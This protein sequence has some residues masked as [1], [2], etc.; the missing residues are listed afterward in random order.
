MDM[1]SMM[2]MMNIS[3][4]S[5]A[6]P[7]FLISIGQLMI[8]WSILILTVR[9]EDVLD[10]SLLTILHVIMAS[11]LFFALDRAL[12]GFQMLGFRHPAWLGL[13]LKTGS[14]FSSLAAGILFAGLVRRYRRVLCY[15]HRVVELLRQINRE[16]SQR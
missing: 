15:R 8:V 7:E 14:G 13:L 12:N 11:L 6:L 2:G 5:I 10:I 3:P 16:L 1:M 9:A 4:L